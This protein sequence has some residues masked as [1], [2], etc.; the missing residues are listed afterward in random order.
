MTYPGE[1]HGFRRGTN[2]IHRDNMIL[3]FF[4]ETLGE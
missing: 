2:A 4:A 1:K 3:N